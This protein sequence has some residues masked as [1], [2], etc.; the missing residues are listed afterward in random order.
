MKEWMQESVTDCTEAENDRH[1]VAK[2]MVRYGGSFISKLGEA[3]YRAD[4]GN[5]AKLRA[6]FPEEWNKYKELGE[7]DA[8]NDRP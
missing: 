4:P 1:I 6:A 5:T 3:L 7:I 8:T 2:A